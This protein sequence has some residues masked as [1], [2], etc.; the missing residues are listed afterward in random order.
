MGKNAVAMH[1]LL[2]GCGRSRRT[3]NDS[4]AWLGV[5]RKSLAR[6]ARGGKSNNRRLIANYQSTAGIAPSPVRLNLHHVDRM[7]DTFLSMRSGL[8]QLYLCGSERKTDTKNKTNKNSAS[9]R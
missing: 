5:T 7:D 9:P 4:V 1:L 2:C 8:S 6:S 3:R